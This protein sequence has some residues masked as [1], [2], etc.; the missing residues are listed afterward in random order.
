MVVVEEIDRVWWTTA[1]RLD[2]RL[3]SDASERPT[4]SDRLISAPRRARLSPRPLGAG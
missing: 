2:I 3:G 4:A 1:A